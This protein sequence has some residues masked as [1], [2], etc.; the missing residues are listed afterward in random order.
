MRSSRKPVITSDEIGHR[1][2]FVSIQARRH[3][4]N[5]VHAHI[6]LSALESLCRQHGFEVYYTSAR[7]NGVTPPPE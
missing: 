1:L 4:G 6:L 2:A 3:D 5:E 7:D